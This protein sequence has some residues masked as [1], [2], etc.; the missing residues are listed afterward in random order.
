MAGLIDEEC[1][2]NFRQ[3]VSIHVGVRTRKKLCDADTFTN[4]IQD[5]A[6]EILLVQ[7]PWKKFGFASAETRSTYNSVCVAR[8]TGD[9]NQEKRLRRK[10]RTTTTRPR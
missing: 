1:R 5:A 6:K 2:T 4:C 7:M 10:L 9:L 3:S 8:S